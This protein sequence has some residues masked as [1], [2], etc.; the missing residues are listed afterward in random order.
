MGRGK[1]KPG[2]LCHK[3]PPNMVPK[4]YETKIFE[5]QQKKTCKNQNTGKLGPE[6]GVMELP[7]PG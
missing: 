3:T 4:N 5:N 6:E 1:E 7:I 2:I